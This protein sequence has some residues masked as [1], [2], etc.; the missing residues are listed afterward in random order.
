NELTFFE[1]AADYGIVGGP[2]LT[3]R[4]RAP[5]I[6]GFRSV[7]G[8]HAY[9]APQAIV[10]EDGSFGGIRFAGNRDQ[11]ILRVPLIGSETVVQH[12]ALRIVDKPPVTGSL[13][14]IPRVE[15]GADCPIRQLLRHQVAVGIVAID[16]LRTSR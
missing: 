7:A 5:E 8:N 12:I 13:D 2:G 11:P 14:L 1:V 4:L 15:A 16:E 10:A 6:T 9:A 3:E